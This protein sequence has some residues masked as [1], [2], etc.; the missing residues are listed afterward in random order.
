MPEVMR[1]ASAPSPPSRSLSVMCRLAA[2]ETRGGAQRHAHANTAAVA[3]PRRPICG[4]FCRCRPGMS[5]HR[6]SLA[7][8][9]CLGHPRRLRLADCAS[10]PAGASVSGAPIF[11]MSRTR[12]GSVPRSPPSGFPSPAHGSR[13]HPGG[14][15]D[16]RQGGD[17]GHARW[18]DRRRRRLLPEPAGEGAR[19][20]GRL[21]RLHRT[22]LL[23]ARKRE[24]CLHHRQH[25]T[26]DTQ[27]VVR[28][29]PQIRLRRPVQPDPVLPPSR[30]PTHLLLF[31]LRPASPWHW[32]ASCGEPLATSLSGT[33]SMLPTVCPDRCMIHALHK[34]RAAFT[35]HPAGGWRYLGRAVR[36][37]HRP[38][39]QVPAHR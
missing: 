1:W 7:A 19:L 37:D 23:H 15:S 9:A 11:S 30:E 35:R 16:L 3:C 20:A 18:R 2:D 25:Q 39:D 26:D 8:Q 36:Q 17:G 31:P 6:R 22:H 33:E 32:P 13:P 27:A 38:G 24:A 28:Q 10:A 12:Q 21:L 14:E 5:P 34:S 4:W 29:A